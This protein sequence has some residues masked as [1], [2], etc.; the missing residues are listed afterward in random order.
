MYPPYAT[1][2]V[3]A[4]ASKVTKRNGDLERYGGHVAAVQTT[5]YVEFGAPWESNLYPT[6]LNKYSETLTLYQRQQNITRNCQLKQVKLPHPCSFS[7]ILIKLK[8]LFHPLWYLNFEEYLLLILK[9]TK[10]LWK[11]LMMMMSYWKLMFVTHCV[12]VTR[13]AELF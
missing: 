13:K 2:F 7:P 6:M 3:N 9:T 11:H 10:I 5:S 12:I 1:G 8:T 4:N